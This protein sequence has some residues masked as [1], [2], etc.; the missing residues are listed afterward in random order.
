MNV[1][2][3]KQL[4][5]ANNLLFKI[6]PSFGELIQPNTDIL[7]G[8][9]LVVQQLLSKYFKCLE[10]SCAGINFSSVFL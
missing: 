7:T 8:I 5:S 10:G 4:I 1:I 6:F 9:V 2:Q 3:Q